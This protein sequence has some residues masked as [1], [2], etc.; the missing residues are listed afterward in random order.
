MG[1]VLIQITWNLWVMRP[2]WQV[3]LDPLCWDGEH[4]SRWD[5]IQTKNSQ[6]WFVS[7]TLLVWIRYDGAFLSFVFS[8]PSARERPL[9]RLPVTVSD[10]S[11]T[12]RPLLELS[13][14]C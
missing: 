10:V 2:V 9:E 8:Q 5:T 6:M 13:R 1:T 12:Q 4:V 7:L 3:E 11:R 14:R